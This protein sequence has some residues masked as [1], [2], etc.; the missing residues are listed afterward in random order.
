M[1]KT[2]YDCEIITDYQLKQEAKSFIIFNFILYISRSQVYSCIYI[3]H[4]EVI[5]WKYFPRYWPFVRGIH[6]SPV[7]YPHKGQC[8]GA[9]MFFYLRLNKRLSKQSWGWWFETLSRPLWR[10]CNA[11]FISQKSRFRGHAWFQNLV[12]MIKQDL[13]FIYVAEK[14]DLS[15]GYL[16]KRYPAIW[17][18]F[19]LTLPCP[20]NVTPPS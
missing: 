12:L 15:R 2:C 5:E 9:L 14:H 3:H 18:H 13:Y 7:N 19:R 10:H 1:S 16:K 8:R 20:D 11:F 6:R 4:D 17:G